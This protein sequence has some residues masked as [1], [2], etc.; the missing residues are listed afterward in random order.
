MNTHEFIFSN[1]TKYRIA[2]HAIFWILF[3]LHFIIQNLMVGGPGEARNSRTFLQSV[4]HSMY[5]IPVYLSTTYFFITVLLTRLLFKKRYTVFAFSFS[6][7][8]I[9]T[10]IA[11][12][13]AG[14]LY[15]H[16]T[17]GKPYYQ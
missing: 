15:L 13:C 9:L 10:F 8:I 3:S 5:F 4:S 7:L 2:R 11:V 12:Y 17:T 16:H 14:L 1:Q 6:S